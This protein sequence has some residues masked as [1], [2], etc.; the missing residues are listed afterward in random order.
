MKHPLHCLLILAAVL[1]AGCASTGTGVNPAARRQG[2][3]QPCQVNG[4]ENC[5]MLEAGLYR[6]AQPT[7]LGI[8][9]LE[10]MGVTN[11]L[12]LRMT[13]TDNLLASS[14]M[15]SCHTVPISYF[16]INEHSILEAV[17]IMQSPKNR[18]LLVHCLHGSDRTGLV[19]ATYRVLVQDWS[20]EEALAEMLEGGF[21]FHTCF[22]N[23]VEFIRNLDVEKARQQLKP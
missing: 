18:P 5:F 6:S 22:T 11:L 2:W 23:I 12:S 17:K 19:C 7:T 14:T 16:H 20:K 15:M 21:G 8:K 4:V 1:V 10:E 3:A 13:S 9:N